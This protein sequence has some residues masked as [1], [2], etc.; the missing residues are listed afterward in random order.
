MGSSRSAFPGGE[1]P[2]NPI[3]PRSGREDQL[4][5]LRSVAKAALRRE[6]TPEEDAGLCEALRTVTREAGSGEPTLPMVVDALLHPR[7]AM[8]R[9]V[10]ATSRDGFAEANRQSAL[11]LQARRPLDPPLLLLLD[12][13]VNIAPPPELDE[14][15]S[16]VRGLGA[17]LLTCFRIDPYAF[18]HHQVDR[19][20]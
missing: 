20:P 6:L 10:S 18:G 13:C 14:I 2:L 8:V 1:V 11:A 19:G 17:Q 5:L 7:E 15:A 12:E 3:T 4:G 9:G 16:T